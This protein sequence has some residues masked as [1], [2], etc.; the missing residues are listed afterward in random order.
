MDNIDQAIAGAAQPAQ[1]MQ[2]QIALPPG[3]SGEQ[4]MAA[5]DLPIPFGPMD[6]LYLTAVLTD[7]LSKQPTGPASRIVVPAR[8]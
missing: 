1:R 6:V 7:A 8:T 4:R 3:P 2:G 5:F